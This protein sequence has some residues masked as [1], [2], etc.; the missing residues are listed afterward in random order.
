MANIVA[1]DSGIIVLLVVGLTDQ[2]LI[3]RH[4]RLQGYT[5]SD[6]K[7]LK[8]IIEQY[9]EAVVIPNALTEA[10]NLL[11]QISEPARTR[12]LSEFRSFIQRIREIYVE[13]QTASNRPEFSR[14]GLTDA[15]ELELAQ[16]NISILAADGPLCRAAS[17][18]GYQALNFR[19][20]TELG[21][22]AA[23]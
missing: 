12:I 7:H 13:S 11:R 5:I 14:L 1:L 21:R 6:F 4:K 17:D 19:E 20:L 23:G 10:G 8:S 15:A 22:F 3:A 9:D 2:N 18:A 16:G